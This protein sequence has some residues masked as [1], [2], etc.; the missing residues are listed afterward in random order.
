MSGDGRCHGSSLLR[1]RAGDVA[2]AKVPN[3]RFEQ[4]DVELLPFDDGKFDLA[5]ISLALCHL[6]DPTDAI[7]ALMVG[8]APVGCR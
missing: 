3:A 4:G 6:A 1:R 7:D 2:R 5:V 8:P